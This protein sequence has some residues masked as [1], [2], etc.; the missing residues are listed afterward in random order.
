M[1][2]FTKLLNCIQFVPT[3]VHAVELLFT[4]KSG[5]DKKSAALTLVGDAIAI[6]DN[7]GANEIADPEKFKDGLGKIVDGVFECLNASVWHK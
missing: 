6:G 5:S 1:G 7:L 2:I 3:A 4:G